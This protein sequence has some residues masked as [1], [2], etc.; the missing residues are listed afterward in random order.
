MKVNDTV[1]ALIKRPIFNIKG[2]G[3]REIIGFVVSIYGF[4]YTL[5]VENIFIEFNNDLLVEM[6]GKKVILTN[7]GLTPNLKQPMFSSIPSLE[8]ERLEIFKQNEVV[9]SVVKKSFQKILCQVQDE[10]LRS[11]H[12]VTISSSSLND[13]RRF[14][15]LDGE[16]TLELINSQEGEATSIDCH[17]EALF[18]LTYELKDMISELLQDIKNDRNKYS[19]FLNNGIEIN[20]TSIVTKKKLQFEKIIFLSLTYPQLREPIR[21]LHEMSWELKGK[22]RTIQK[23]IEQENKSREAKTNLIE[24][25]NKN[26]ISLLKAKEAL[27]RNIQKRSELRNK[28]SQSG[29]SSQWLA[30][31]SIWLSEFDSKIIDISQQV[32]RYESWIKEGKE[33]LKNWKD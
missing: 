6:L 15:E 3:L 9:A 23:K 29:N 2:N 12:F 24:N 25:I 11:T 32:T 19:T 4:H 16:V 10:K 21:Y 26:E 13:D 5:P 31:A 14:L 22:I 27:D 8:K 20:R 33:K 28:M 17:D 1:E 30:K 18:D 7:I